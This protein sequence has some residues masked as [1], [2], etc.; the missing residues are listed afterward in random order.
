MP[1][2]YHHGKLRSAL[3]T[4]ALQVIADQGLRGFSVAEVAR[5]VGVSTAAPYR[6]FADRESLLAAVAGTVADDL[7]ERVRRAAAR[8]VEPVDQLA[9]AAGSYTEFMI[10]NRAGLH[11]IFT[12]DLR[13]S[14]HDRLHQSRRSLMDRFLA[15]AF[16]ASPDPHQALELMEQLLAQAHGYA[17]FHLDGVFTRHGYDTELVVHKSVRAARIVITERTTRESRGAGDL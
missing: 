17:T 13:D 4:G 14:R 16:A 15:L 3:I 2:R 12:S 11:V 7:A 5:R 9:A 6:H 8:Y 10:E 1:H